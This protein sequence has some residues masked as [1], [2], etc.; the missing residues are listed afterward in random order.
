MSILSAL[1][2]A[3]QGI[4]EWSGAVPKRNDFAYTNPTISQSRTQQAIQTAGALPGVTPSGGGSAPVASAA[5]DPYAKYGGFGA[6]QNLL[7]SFQSQKNNL[8]NSAMEAGDA[9]AREYRGGILDF[10]DS[11]KLGQQKV[12]NSGIQAE[13]AKKQG[14]QGVLDMVGRG[15]R[16]GGVMLANKNASNSSAR[17]ALARAY[18]ELGQREQSGVNNQ[19]GQAQNQIAQDQAA[20]EMS[21]T[22]NMRKL[23]DSKLSV[24]DQIIQDARSQLGSL[25]ASMANADIGQ[26]INIEA[27]KENIR[28]QLIGKLSQYDAMLRDGSNAVQ[29][30]G[31]DTRR[32]K[33]AELAAAG[34]GA[35]NPYNFTAE[36]PAE[37]QNTGPY[38]SNLP[39]FTLNRRRT[40]G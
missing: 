7:S 30:M 19:Y 27:E 3:W 39:I 2:N 15:I 11:L 23:E 12:D 21:R 34:R 16:S 35:D 8:F 32:G 36:M 28:N 40:Q 14:T 10:L 9:R 20:L 24:I 4:Q 17:E 33:A 18:S 5:P 25:D 29:A 31:V 26:R 6:Y 38:A 37:F 1:G 22:S 13:L